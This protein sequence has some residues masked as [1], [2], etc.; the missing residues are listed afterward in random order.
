MSTAFQAG[1][2][3]AQ[4]RAIVEDLNALLKNI[5]VPVVLESLHDLAPSLL[6]VTL[7]L[8]LQDRL[9]I[10]QATRTAKDV[11]S[12]DNEALQEMDPRMLA[13]GEWD[14]LVT[15]AEALVAVGRAYGLV[16]ESS[17]GSAEDVTTSP[18]THARSAAPTSQDDSVD[19]FWVPRQ[20]ERS[21]PS[22]RSLAPIK[23]QRSMRTS[24]RSSTLGSTS[25]VCDSPSSFSSSY[26]R[27]RPI[28]TSFATT[29]PTVSSG[30]PLTLYRS[31]DRSYETG[32]SS[33]SRPGGSSSTSTKSVPRCIHEVE[34]PEDDISR[35]FDESL[36]LAERS[37]T[38]SSILPSMQKN[39]MKK[40]PVR[41]SGWIEP[42][43]DEEEI[44][45]F[46]ARQRSRFSNLRSPRARP[47]YGGGLSNA[48]G[49]TPKTPSTSTPGR[50]LTR[51]N[52]PSQHTLALMNERAKLLEELA[53]LKAAKLR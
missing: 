32:S 10:P 40:T 36:S 44:R 38:D 1:T 27:S 33:R 11:E 24:A 46:E 29:A 23:T 6:V 52:S 17:S 9:P 42:V 51:H 21:V 48:S 20:T 3:D 31:D 39:T 47:D 43:D 41:Y 5:S 53:S 49:L 15:V 7:E 37:I 45:S 2:Y 18:Q 22:P 26:G 19:P 50:L 34:D 12:R 14:E 16:S 4:I 30:S 28:E 8:I 25:I 35:S 13:I